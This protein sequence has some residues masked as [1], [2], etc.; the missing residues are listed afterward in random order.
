MSD[1]DF[2]NG[3]ELRDMF[4]A[5]T[6]WL[7]KN[8]REIDLLNVFPVPDGDTGTNM[9]LT[10]RAAM[11][12]ASRCPERSAAAVLQAMAWGALMG[13]R[14][15]S[16]VILAQIVRGLAQGLDGKESID[17]H[18]FAAALANSSALAYKAVSQPVEGTILTVVREAAAS[19]QPSSSSDASDLCSILGV[20]VAEARASVART[21]SLL[22]VLRQAGVVDAGGQGLCVLLE[23]ALRHLRGEEAVTTAPQPTAA[24]SQKQ[25]G[26]PSYGYCTEFLIQGSELNIEQIRNRLCE[27][28][29][30]V[31]VIGDESMV[32]AH[33]HTLDPGMAISYATSLGVL[34]QVKV[35]NME[36][37]HRE[38]IAQRAALEYVPLVSI[39]AVVSGEGLS[40]VFTSLGA[41]IVPGGETMNPS[42]Q[43]LLQAVDSA[44]AD[45]VIIL[46]NNPDILPAVAQV[47][48]LAGKEVAVVPSESIPQGI[49]ALLAFNPEIDLGPNLE[50]MQRALSVVRTGELTTAVRSMKWDKLEVHQGHAIAFLDGDLVAAGDT[51]PAA[52]QGLLGRM[53]VGRNELITVYYGADAP[54]AEV[55]EIAQFISRKYP[56]LGL[57]IVAGGQPHYNYIISVE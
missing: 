51:M 22:P 16:G 57:E 47:K 30:S 6:V 13:A 56:Q 43:E 23:G 26:E 7:E 44:P 36:E 52:L 33:L 9:V 48:S 10:M 19:V 34:R 45:K 17:G 55:E 3:P 40:Q 27:L 50:A 38:F 15:N 8:A 2:Y 4:A 25:A 53:G 39:V 20:L 49:A 5:A 21:P 18:D 35:D 46:P 1:R 11:E 24:V 12:E 29:E 42:V 14:G 54:D 32:R 37:Q 31:L 28:G 41:A